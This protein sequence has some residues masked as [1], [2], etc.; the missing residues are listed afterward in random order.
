MYYEAYEKENSEFVDR[1]NELKAIIK[2]IEEVPE[3]HR[4]QN[5]YFVDVAKFTE[6]LFKVVKLI[7]K[8]K[9]Y[10]LPME[11]VK[12][13]N[14]KL[15]RD[16]S[17]ED[18]ETSY[19]NPSFSVSIFG[20]QLGKQLAYVYKRLRDCIES[21]FSNK[22]FNIVPALELFVDVYNALLRSPNHPKGIDKII[23]EN[24]KKYNKLDADMYMRKY[25]D[26]SASYLK[27]I[28]TETDLTDLRYL[29]MYDS[30]I[31]KREVSIAEFFYSLP[32]SKIEAM[33]KTYTDGYIRGFAVNNLDIKKKKYVNIYYSIGFER[34]ARKAYENFVEAGLTPVFSLYQ[35]YYTNR[36]YMYDHRFDYALY[37]D[38]EYMELNYKNTE[39]ACKKY[40]EE[41]KK[42]GGPAAI[43]T[44]G[45]KKFQPKND[46]YAISLDE[47]QLKLDIE[48]K[49]KIGIL[50]SKYMVASE[51]SFTIISY[52]VPLIG[53]NFQDI[54]EETVK[55]NNLDNELYKGIQQ[56]IIDVLDK[57]EYVHVLGMNKN[58]TD[59][60]VSL[61]KLNNPEK[62]TLF[63]NCVADVNIPLGEV[64]TSPRLTNTNGRIYV[65]EVF[66]EGL[67]YL[68][69]D[70]VIKD[71]M[72]ESYNCS[73]FPKEEDN[74]KYIKENV[75]NNHETLPIGEFAIGTNT[76]AYI[77]GQKYN[78]QEQLPILIAEKTGPHFALGDTCY[79]MA[80]DNKTYNPDGK[81]II[82][83]DNEITIKRK[84]DIEKA[85]FNCHTDI[86]IP[87]NELGEISV[88]TKD[89]EKIE[90]IKEGRFV[91]AGTEKLNEAFSENLN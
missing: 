79:S 36:Q 53:D 91:L 29:Y 83:K 26:P 4:V 63:E 89:N 22:L 25:I 55:L 59:I 84:T 3:L 86:T 10:E 45:E 87:Y 39:E 24:A 51:T 70:I 73:N 32:E 14:K 88:Y 40:S 57:G 19:A 23:K 68:D 62:E 34:M 16:I 60:K 9:F 69:L 30:Y 78:I 47:K 37:L 5:R 28:V 90:I 76:T 27:Y 17:E 65:S 48:S 46:R 2:Q 54:F 43:E 85:Y 1:Y 67:K 15:Y 82:A 44:F 7:S 81:E 21:A 61:N 11:K 41:L 6:K 49:R 42:Y 35:P 33:A 13:I 66:L 56:K 64:F 8:N 77:M 74:K 75:L 80:E 58:K 12:K 50:R 72:V 18:Y 20:E 71:G 31:S 52:P 38:E